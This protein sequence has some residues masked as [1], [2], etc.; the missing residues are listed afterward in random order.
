M[1]SDSSRSQPRARVAS[2]AAPQRRHDRK[3]PSRRARAGTAAQLR[4]PNTGYD[5]AAQDPINSDDLDGTAV[6]NPDDSTSVCAREECVNFKDWGKINSVAEIA[7]GTVEVVAVAFAPFAAV[8]AIELGAAVATSTGIRLTVM[9]TTTTSPTAPSS[10][11][12][13]FKDAWSA[14]GNTQGAPVSNLAR[15]GIA[16]TI[17][18]AKQAADNA[19]VV[20]F[21]IH[22]A[23]KAFR[24]R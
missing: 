23:W 2:V 13:A 16:V 5:Y 1:P 10:L 4:R 8:G 24:N 3:P 17:T 21:T 20:R 11:G 14:Y 7:K 22:V 19:W 15:A 18:S 9:L 6:L 12:N